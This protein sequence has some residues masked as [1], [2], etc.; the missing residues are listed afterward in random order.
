[1]ESITDPASWHTGTD[2]DPWL[3]RDRF[4]GEGIAAYGRFFAKKPMFIADRYFP[5]VKGALGAEK[6]VE[7][8]YRDGLLSNSTLKIYR[9]IEAQDGIDARSLRKVTGMQHKED[10]NEFDKAL[11]EL[12]SAF[13]IVIV[14]ISEKLNS[15]GLKSGWNSTCY[16]LAERWMELHELPVFEGSKQ[17]A[18]LVLQTFLQSQWNPAAYQYMLKIIAKGSN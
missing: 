10:K 4:A 8:R 13:H 15:L 1:M 16:I 2:I 7:Q 12:Q 3:W 9:A 6:P 11:I 5:L 14:G 18:K 17:E